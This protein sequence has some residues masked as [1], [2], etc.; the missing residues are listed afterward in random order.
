MLNITA[1]SSDRITSSC[2]H[3]VHR[4]HQLAPPVAPD[5]AVYAVALAEGLRDDSGPLF[6]PSLANL[7][8]LHDDRAR[9]FAPAEFA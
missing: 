2:A 8:D 6:E 5:D 3:L 9:R 4:E 1:F 7:L